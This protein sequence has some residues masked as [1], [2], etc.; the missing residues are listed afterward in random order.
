MSCE[1]AIFAPS[2]E[3]TGSLPTNE[4]TLVLAPVTRSTV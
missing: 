2:G 4:S 3:K 1:Y